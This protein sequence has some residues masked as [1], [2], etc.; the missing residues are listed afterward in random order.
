MYLVRI[1]GVGAIKSGR[2]HDHGD[3]RQY[4]IAWM[5]STRLQSD[6]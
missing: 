4:K 6:G 1:Y 3:D 2:L 5:Q